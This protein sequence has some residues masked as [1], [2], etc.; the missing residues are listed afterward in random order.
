M[1]SDVRMPA[2]DDEEEPED[3][4]NASESDDSN[5]GPQYT[6]DTPESK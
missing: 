5:D 6:S 3:Y 4:D 2:E 1:E